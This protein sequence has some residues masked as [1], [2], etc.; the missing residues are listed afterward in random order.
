MTRK[1]QTI[2]HMLQLLCEK[3]TRPSGCLRQSWRLGPAY[4]AL[5]A[6][7]VHDS[8][9]MRSG[10]V[11]LPIVPGYTKQLWIDRVARQPIWFSNV[12]TYAPGANVCADTHAHAQR[13]ALTC[14]N[15]GTD[16]TV[17]LYACGRARTRALRKMRGWGKPNTM[18]SR[19]ARDNQ[20]DGRSDGMHAIDR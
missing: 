6:S 3:E 10:E 9:L 8:V 12:V 4:V 16:V 14:T 17:R 5:A 1:P 19:T 18:P 13:F 2:Q 15:T 7:S 20:R 11:L